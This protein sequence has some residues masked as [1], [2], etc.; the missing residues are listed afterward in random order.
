MTA[1][2]RGF[3]SYKAEKKACEGPVMKKKH[4]RN[5]L[6]AQGV[7]VLARQLAPLLG[8]GF[9]SAA[10]T[11][12]AGGSFLP[13][14]HHAAAYLGLRAENIIN[15]LVDLIRQSAFLEVAHGKVVGQFQYHAAILG[16]IA[17]IILPGRQRGMIAQQ[18][19]VDHMRVAIGIL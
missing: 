13:H 8:D 12:H 19:I 11:L 1:M 5:A 2:R 9:L 6:L 16:H 15:R 10:L 3:F 4:K 17:H 14:A 18:D 7:L